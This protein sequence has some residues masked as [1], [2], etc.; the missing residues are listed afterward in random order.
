M[1]VLMI[2]GSPKPRGNTMRALGEVSAEL[3]RL[4]ISSE[5][6]PIG[7]KPIAG[8]IACGACSR[9]GGRC[10]VDDGL[11]EGLKEKMAAADA[12]VVGT[13]VYYAHPN[14]ALLACLDR[15]FYS[16][17]SSIFRYKPYAAIAIA[18][19][20]GTVASFDVLNKY[21][22]ITEMPVVGNRYWNDAFGRAP[23]E[24]EGDEEGLAIMRQLARNLAW[25]LRCIEAGRAAGVGDPEPREPVMTN[26]IR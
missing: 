2:S 13:P 16:A 22:T 19:R 3:E 23:G 7:A 11:V 14:G 8:C 1:H 24:V 5:I 18:R 21:A 17:D 6:V 9:N 26:F 15:L 25:L 4:G 10:V 20:A 12:L